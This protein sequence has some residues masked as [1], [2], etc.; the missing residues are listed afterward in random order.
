V[1]SPETFGYTLVQK[2]GL[3]K[4]DFNEPLG[5]ILGI[6]YGNQQI[7]AYLALEGRI[8]QFIEGGSVG[9]LDGHDVPVVVDTG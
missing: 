4:G 7:N 9:S 5:L 8:V 2:H 6:D 3:T 1:V